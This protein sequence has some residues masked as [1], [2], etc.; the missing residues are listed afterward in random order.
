MSADNGICIVKNKEGNYDVRYYSAS[1][2]YV[3]EEDMPLIEMVK[4]L[5]EAIVIGQ[6]QETEYGLH[7]I[8]LDNL[9]ADN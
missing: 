9:K 5:E 8:G 2:D 3:K 7:F 6:E 4:T 1:V